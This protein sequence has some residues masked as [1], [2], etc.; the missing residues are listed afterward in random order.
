[1]ALVN[2]P[3]PPPSVV[4]DDDI[5]GYGEVLQQTPQAVTGKSPAE[6]TFPPP[7]AV[8]A[9]IPVIVEVVTVGSTAVV[10]VKLT[11]SP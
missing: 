3:V 8:V 9:V 2:C 6:V 11:L 4:I 1:M 10:V 7:T 5:S